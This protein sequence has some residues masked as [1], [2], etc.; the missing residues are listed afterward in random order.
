MCLNIKFWNF[1]LAKS[2][3]FQRNT[4]IQYIININKSKFLIYVFAKIFCNIFFHS[5]INYGIIAW[6]GVYKD[7]MTRLKYSNKN[8]KNCTQKLFRRK[9][10]FTLEALMYHYQ[11]LKEIYKKSNN[12]T[13]NK[14]IQ[15]PKT[16]K[17]VSNKNSYMV[18]QKTYN[19]LPKESKSVYSNKNN[20]KYTLRNKLKNYIKSTYIL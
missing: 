4:H 20:R 16:K 3:K 1:Y 6:G 15:L 19:S 9:H 13:K 7:N 14:S 17:A 5:Y 10:S 11:D 2:L 8:L 18:T 12:K